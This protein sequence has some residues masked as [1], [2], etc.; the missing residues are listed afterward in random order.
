MEGLLCSDAGLQIRATIK[1][2]SSLEGIVISLP[3]SDG[4]RLSRSHEKERRGEAGPTKSG[5]V[6]ENEEVKR[7]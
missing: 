2:I 1:S 3:T 5:D 7:W 4:K 6:T